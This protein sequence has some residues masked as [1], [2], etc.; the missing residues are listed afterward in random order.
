MGIPVNFS[1]PS[2]MT[3]QQYRTIIWISSNGSM[4]LRRRSMCLSTFSLRISVAPWAD[5]PQYTS[6]CQMDFTNSS[7]VFRFRSVL[8]L[9]HITDITSSRSGWV[10]LPDVGVG[11]PSAPQQNHP[12]CWSLKA[13]GTTATVCSCAGTVKIW[14]P[15]IGRIYG[16]TLP[17]SAPGLQFSSV[18]STHWGINEWVK[19]GSIPWCYL[20]VN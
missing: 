19:A 20:L 15:R 8:W 1:E 12:S 9:S 11:Q 17:G 6:D 18:C 3:V 14:W 13:R 7:G 16:Q 4:S 10:M 5:V 2:F